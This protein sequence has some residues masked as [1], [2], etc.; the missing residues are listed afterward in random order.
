MGALAFI[1]LL[2][3]LFL[4]AKEGMVPNTPEGHTKNLDGIMR[5]SSKYSGKEMRKRINKGD[6]K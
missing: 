5:D 2:V 4:W 1:G 3:G 6:Y